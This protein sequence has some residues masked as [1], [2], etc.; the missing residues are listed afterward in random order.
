MSHIM[1]GFLSNYKAA[2]YERLSRED[3]RKDESSSI[4]SQKML[5][6]PLLNLIILQLSSIIVMMDLQDLTSIVPASSN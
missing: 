2:G 3:D 1:N 4:A 6:I 5:L